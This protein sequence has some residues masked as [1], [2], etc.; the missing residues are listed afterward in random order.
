YTP[1]ERNVVVEMLGNGDGTFKP[2]QTVLVTKASGSVPGNETFAVGD[3]NG[4]RSPDLV[5]VNTYGVRVSINNGDGTFQPA[6][7][8]SPN[9]ASSVVIADVNADGRADLVE[10]GCVLLGNGDG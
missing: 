1:F 7:T 10:P 9:T 2:L 3:V 6:H 4:D 5:L 8:V